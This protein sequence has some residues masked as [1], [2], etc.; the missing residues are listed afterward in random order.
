MAWQSQLLGKATDKKNI[1]MIP[2]IYI[3]IQMR[4]SIGQ[5]SGWRSLNQ[6]LKSLEPVISQKPIK[7]AWHSNNRCKKI[8]RKAISNGIY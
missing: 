1:K 5:E 3:A 6:E 4:F 8:N 7:E 2:S